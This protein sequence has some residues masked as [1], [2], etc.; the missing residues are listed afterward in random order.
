MI[1][2]HLDQLQNSCAGPLAQVDGD[3]AYVRGAEQ[4]LKCCNVALDHVHDV[5]VIANACAITCRVVVAI[6]AERF[7]LAERN[8]LQPG[9]EVPGHAYRVLT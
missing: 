1:Y 5:G 9:H 2:A 6:Q 3:T 4:L 8:C 7:A